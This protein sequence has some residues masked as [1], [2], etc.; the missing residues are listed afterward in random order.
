MPKNLRGDRAVERMR[1]KGVKAGEYPMSYRR[2]CCI[3]GNGDFRQG[4]AHFFAVA[5]RVEYARS[6]HPWPRDAAGPAEAAAALLDEAQE[7]A[8]AVIEGPGRME[9]EL[10]DVG[11][12]MVRELNR[13]WERGNG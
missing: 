6:K 8:D 7:V 5:E 10:Y 2:A 9:D 3:W 12:V 11:A 4:Q 13:E 1:K